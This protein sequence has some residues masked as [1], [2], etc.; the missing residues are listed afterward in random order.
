MT[1]KLALVLIAGLQAGCS[2]GIFGVHMPFEEGPQWV[3]K[4][5]PH[6]TI[7]DRRP[8]AERKLHTG[9]GLSSCQRW[10]GDDSYVP[11]KIAYLEQLLAERIPQTPV[12]IQ[13]QRFD[14]V[15]FCDNTANRAAAG[16]AAGATGVYIPSKDVRGGNS[17]LVRLAGD[18]N[19][20][21][22]DVS[23]RFDYSDLKYNELTQMPADNATYRER[24]KQAVVAIVDEIIAKLPKDS[25]SQSN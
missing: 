2:T 23:R 16:A 3:A 8:A 11:A 17:V 18:I 4:T 12:Q 1:R 13:L 19:G 14:T 21:S 5:A 24:M 6:I 25:V 20:E 22:F 7:D 10:Y 15:E 9:G